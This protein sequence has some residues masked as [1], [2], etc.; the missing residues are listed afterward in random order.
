MKTFLLTLAVVL[1]IPATALFAQGTSKNAADSTE[2]IP[3][4]DEFIQT[5][6][7]PSFDMAELYSRLKYPEEARKNYIQGRVLIQIF[8][9]REGK[10]LQT[11]ILQSDNPLLEEAA[12]TAIK[13]TAFTPAIQF[14]KPLGVWMVIPITFSLK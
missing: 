5:E 8:I 13:Q 1:T 6:V 2:Q 11:R 9:S 7:D 10:I 4:P 3:E 12:I 14:G